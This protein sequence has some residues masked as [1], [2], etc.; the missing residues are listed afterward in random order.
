MKASEAS[1]L[2]SAK[3]RNINWHM[4]AAVVEEKLHKLGRVLVKAGFEPNQPRVPAG[5]PD[6]GQWTSTGG[7]SNA[8]GS[9]TLD[10]IVTLARR[11]ASA[12]SLLDYQRCLDLCYPLLERPQHPASDGN[13]WDFH[14][15][16]NA[17][18]KLNL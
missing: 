6:G 11:I 2:V 4:R 3:L 7:S 14:R 16:M 12:G 15:C 1:W 13:M 9:T 17:C 5:N 10:K 8:T 18:L